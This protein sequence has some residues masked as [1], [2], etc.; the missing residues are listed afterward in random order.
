MNETQLL[1][2]VYK[3]FLLQCISFALSFFFLLDYH[4][5]QFY[6]YPELDMNQ[7]LQ[8]TKQHT[9]IIQRAN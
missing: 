3:S 9:A 5:C 8:K 2:C 1:N 4:S 6:F 7:E